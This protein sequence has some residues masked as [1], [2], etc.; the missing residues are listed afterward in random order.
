MRLSKV[1]S[2]LLAAG[3]GAGLTTGYTH[4]NTLAVGADQVASQPT[5]VAVAKSA[6]AAANLPD[7]T[8]L[9]ER[10][11][12]SVVNISTFH[13]KGK[14]QATAKDRDGYGEARSRIAASGRTRSLPLD[15]SRLSCPIRRLRTRPARLPP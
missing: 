3:I 10:A 4:F 12:A 2:A 8:A 13:A 14:G 9:V 15:R 7:F 5:S 6:T 1:T 11:G